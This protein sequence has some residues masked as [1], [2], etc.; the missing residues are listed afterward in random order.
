MVPGMSDGQFT[1]KAAV[2]VGHNSEGGARARILANIWCVNCR[3]SVQVT[4]FSGEEEKG[5]LILK[6]SC[7]QCGHE[8][9]RVVETSEMDLSGN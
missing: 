4:K 9:V 1:A 6:G 5:D 3:T 7:G 8:V 2:A